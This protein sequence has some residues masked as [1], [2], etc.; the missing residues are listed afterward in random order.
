MKKLWLL[1]PVVVSLA[2]GQ[3]VRGQN[4]PS[5]KEPKAGAAQEQ[6]TDAPP[7]QPQLQATPDSQPADGQPQGEAQPQPDAAP[8]QPAPE[9]PQP[10]QTSPAQP[11]EPAVDEAT[12]ENRENAEQPKGNAPTDV[13]PQM[14]DDE[15]AKSSQ[16]QENP[17]ISTTE[18]DGRLVVST[19]EPRFSRIGL[20]RD[21]VIVSIDGQS[22]SRSADFR[23]R[24][25]AIR[26]GA[27]IP[28]IILRGGVRQTIYWSPVVAY[29]A[30]DQNAGMP[31]GYVD[32]EDGPTT[33]AYLGV[34]F[35]TR[36]PNAAVVLAVTPGSPAEQAGLQPGDVIVR[37][38]GQRVRDARSV[39]RMVSRHP[40]GAELD[41][42]FSRLQTSR[43]QLGERPGA[44]RVEASRV[45][46]A[47]DGETAAPQAERDGRLFD[48]DRR[49]LDRRDN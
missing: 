13:R 25:I 16:D 10:E 20:R 11:A 46:Y 39:S 21:D 5:S 44:V 27:R 9:Q 33:N 19:I 42:Q 43:V 32:Y 38:D 15:A 35:N 47:A 18:R 49:L 24:L 1:S 12:R 2:L 17:G 41:L 48:G 45:P 4:E 29:R 34:S 8:A 37:L 31:D 6:K 22:V 14:N 7:A 30:D 28:I 23:R 36:Y 3:S 40:V 26:P